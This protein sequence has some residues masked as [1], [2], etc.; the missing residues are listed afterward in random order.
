MDKVAVPILA[1]LAGFAARGLVAAGVRGAAR[2]GLRRTLLTLGKRGIKSDINN[3]K[4]LA[5]SPGKFFGGLKQQWDNAGKLGRT[6]QAVTYGFSGY[7][8]AHGRPAD[9]L[10]Y[11]AAPTLMFGR[12]AIKGTNQFFKNRL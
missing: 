3:V 9:A 5:T 10:G 2:L 12:D 8:L 7:D 1:P 4:T 6:G 11:V